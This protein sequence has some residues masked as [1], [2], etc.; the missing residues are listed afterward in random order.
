MAATVVE[1]RSTRQKSAIRSAFE[2]TG[3]PLSAQQVLELAQKEVDGVGIA[4]VYRNIKALLEEGWLSLVEL[5][6]S[7]PVY[8]RAGKRH[9]HHFQCDHC[10][11]VFELEGCLPSVN[12]LAGPKFQ[13]RSHEIVLYGLC[14]DCKRRR[15][16]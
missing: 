14:G 1:R 3:R 6:G 12:K 9:H 4:T 7:A 16:A 5:P 10:H 8:E 13:V 15:P 11:R 2:R